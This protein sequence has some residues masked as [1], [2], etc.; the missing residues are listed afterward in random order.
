MKAPPKASTQPPSD[1][2]SRGTVLATQV[3]AVANKLTDAQR[4]DLRAQGMRI[5]YGGGHGDKVV[6]ANRR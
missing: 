4:Q 2:P 6:A 1:V 5:I 3:R